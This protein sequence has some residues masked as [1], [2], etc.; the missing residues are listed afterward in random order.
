M[1]ILERDSYLVQNPALGAILLW[2]FARAYTNTHKQNAS[3]LLPHLFLPLPMLWHEPTAEVISSTITSSGLRLFASKFKSATD[4]RL[5]ILLDL[6]PRAIA[7]RH[8]SMNSIMIAHASGL[9][10]L[11]NKAYVHPFDV[12]WSNEKQPKKIKSMCSSAIKLGTWFAPLSLSEI[13][14]I[15]SIRF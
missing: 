11:D 6:N 2:Q 9:V 1:S 10:K 15:L 12:E 5:D 7:W 8:K 14:A 13:S 3:P 4:S